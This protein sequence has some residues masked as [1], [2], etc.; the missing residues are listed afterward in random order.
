MQI[1]FYRLRV[2]VAT[3]ACESSIC[4]I[5]FSLEGHKV[6]GKLHKLLMISVDHASID[7]KEK[8]MEWKENSHAGVTI[9]HADPLQFCSRMVPMVHICNQTNTNKNGYDHLTLQFHSRM[10]KWFHGP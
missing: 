6:Q 9:S 10:A 1:K 5:D 8:S 7:Y 4:S 3:T 2:V